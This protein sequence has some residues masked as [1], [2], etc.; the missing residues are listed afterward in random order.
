MCSLKQS[1]K[2]QHVFL[3]DPK[4]WEDFGIFNGDRLIVS[5]QTPITLIHLLINLFTT[6]MCQELCWSWNYNDKQQSDAD[7]A[8][9]AAYR[10]SSL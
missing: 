4:Y 3:C 10:E 2:Q 1:S 6:N 8:Y 5:I 7:P 9:H